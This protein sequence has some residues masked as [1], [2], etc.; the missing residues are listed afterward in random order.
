M[1]LKTRRLD[2]ESTPERGE[3]AEAVAVLR[4][5]LPSDEREL[6]REI[7]ERAERVASILSRRRALLCG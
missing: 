2:V 3:I 7:D 1:K 5:P 4:A 6:S